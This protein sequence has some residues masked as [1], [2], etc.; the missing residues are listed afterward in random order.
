MSFGRKTAIPLLIK[1]K[2]KDLQK[3]KSKSIEKSRASYREYTEIKNSRSPPKD[4]DHSHEASVH[5]GQFI[6]LKPKTLPYDLIIPYVR[7]IVSHQH[8]T[9][10]TFS[11]FDRD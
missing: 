5:E 3:S 7:H 1:R 11:L 2:K 10:K 8:M 4:Q 6:K 9:S